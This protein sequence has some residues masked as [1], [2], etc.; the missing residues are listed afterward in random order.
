M[1]GGIPAVRSAI[2]EVKSRVMELG[3]RARGPLGRTAQRLQHSRLALAADQ[4]RSLGAFLK[5]GPTRPELRRCARPRDGY[6]GRSRGRAM[7]GFDVYRSQVSR[8]VIR[9][10]ATHGPQKVSQSLE[11][12]K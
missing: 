7:A 11:N 12:P 4:D 6:W 10:A 5:P 2:A 3:F 1:G 8:G 9:D